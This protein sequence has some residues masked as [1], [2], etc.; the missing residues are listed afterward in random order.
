MSDKIIMPTELTAE[1]GAKALLM[2]EFKETHTEDCPFC[3]G[4]GYLD[5]D[6]DIECD[7]CCGQGVLVTSVTVSWDTIKEIYKLAASK[8]GQPVN[9]GRE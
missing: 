4:S 2:G 7:V 9:R 8:L 1:N 3:D 5:A 6:E